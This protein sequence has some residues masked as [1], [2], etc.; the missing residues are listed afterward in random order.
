MWK[1]GRRLPNSFSGNICFEFSVL[2]LCSAF[3]LTLFSGLSLTSPTT[4]LPFT[5]ESLFCCRHGETN[6]GGIEQYKHFISLTSSVH[7]PAAPTKIGKQGTTACVQLSDAFIKFW[8]I[9]YQTFTHVTVHCTVHKTST[10]T[11]NF[12]KERCQLYNCLL[13]SRH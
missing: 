8:S 3:L 5:V 4:F 11:R 1:L 6:N 7:I 12:C 9:M 13:F 10:K 2:C